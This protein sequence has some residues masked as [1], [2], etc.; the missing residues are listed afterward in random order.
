[1]V[2]VVPTCFFFFWRKMTDS[3]SCG[4]LQKLIS[5]PSNCHVKCAAGGGSNQP[6]CRAN[7]KNYWELLFLEPKSIGLLKMCVHLYYYNNVSQPIERH[8]SWATLHFAPDYFVSYCF[9]TGALA[10]FSLRYH[11]MSMMTSSS[12]TKTC[13][14]IYNQHANHWCVDHNPMIFYGVKYGWTCFCCRIPRL[15]IEKCPAGG[16]NNQ[17]TCRA[18]YCCW[19]SRT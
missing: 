1:M 5:S 11:V 9:K 3:A 17:A 10:P 2:N 4:V 7:N 18:K 6:T 14:Y 16:C 8:Y 13:W 12:R 19:G 15:R